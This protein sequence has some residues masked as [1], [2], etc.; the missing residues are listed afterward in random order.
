MKK[1]VVLDKQIGETPL[2]ALQQWK[3]K[4]PTYTNMPASYAGRLDPMASGKLLVLLGNECKRQRR[5]SSLDKEYEIEVLLDIGSDTGDV[6]GMPEYA[7]RETAPDTHA[8]ANMFNVELGA[9][10]RAYPIFSSKTVG[11]KPL[12]L[13]ALEGTLSNI[14]I[15]EHVERIYHIK[16]NGSYIIHS[17]ELTARISTLL[18]RAPRTEESSKRLGENFRIDAIR[19]Q[20]ESVFEIARERN[21]SV[22]RLKITCS[23]GTYMRSLAGRVGTALG[24]KALAISIRRTKIGTYLPLWRGAGFWIRTY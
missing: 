8:L 3:V 13:Y 14:Q 21:F 4:N 1:I 18:D 24:T 12:F 15:P 16:H 6:L 11:G 9:H 17:T 19:A 20:W 22:L 7:V 10:A 23:S 2:F 5:Y